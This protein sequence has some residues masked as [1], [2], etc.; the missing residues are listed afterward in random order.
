MNYMK[1][2]GHRPKRILYE[3]LYLGYRCPF[4]FL[5]NHEMAKSYMREIT[6]SEATGYIPRIVLTE[7]YCKTWQKFGKRFAQL[8]VVNTKEILE[9]LLIEENDIFAIGELK[10]KNPFL[11]IVDASL[12]SLSKQ[13]GA[14][15]LTTDCA[16]CDVD[17]FK[18]KKLKY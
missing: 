12:M 7:F 17:G 11:S 8:R 6:R 16:I 4:S 5:V 2:V 10:V 1:N 15:I 14:T 9:E 13:V 3:T 18:S